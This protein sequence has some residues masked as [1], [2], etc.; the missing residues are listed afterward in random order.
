MDS[1]EGAANEDEEKKCFYVA[2]LLSNT[3]G[4]NFYLCLQVIQTNTEI[5]I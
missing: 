2:Q 1:E 3:V 4:R 5:T